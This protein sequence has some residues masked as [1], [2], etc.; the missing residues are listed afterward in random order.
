MT[1][2]LM[3]VR[4]SNSYNKNKGKHLE[5]LNKIFKQKCNFKKV[6]YSKNYFIL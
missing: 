4:V 1:Q 5:V 6:T 3:N 2:S